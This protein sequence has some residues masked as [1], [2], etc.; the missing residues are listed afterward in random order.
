MY[1]DAV[2]EGD[3][4][5]VG[6]VTAV[7]REAVAALSYDLDGAVGGARLLGEQGGEARGVGCADGDAGA[8][9]GARELGGVLVGDEP[10]PLQRD[11]VVGGACGLLGV[12]RGQQDRATLGRVCAQRAVQPTALAGREPVRGIVEDE[13]VRIG[14]ERAG[15]TE[16]AVHA[17]REGA[18]AFVAQADEADHLQDLVG[19]PGRHTRRGAQHAQ[20]TA[21]RARR[22]PGDIAEEHADLPRGMRHAVQGAAPEEGDATALLEFEHES[23]RRRLARSRHSEQRG[24]T[25]RTSLE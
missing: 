16:A 15:Q 25:S 22:M 12:G 11:D 4:A 14:K 2:A 9:A 10:A 3:L 17:A 21:H 6:A 7:H 20:M 19:T 13:R 18:E 8:Q 23:E 1:E 5:D 24:D